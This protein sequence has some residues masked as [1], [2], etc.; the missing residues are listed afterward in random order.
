MTVLHPALNMGDVKARWCNEGCWATVRPQDFL[1]SAG[2]MNGRFTSKP[3]K[4]IGS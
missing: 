1:T 4:L 3:V 2:D